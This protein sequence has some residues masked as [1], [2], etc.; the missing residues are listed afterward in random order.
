MKLLRQLGI[1][2]LICMIGEVIQKLT[3]IPIPGN[4]L[5]MIILLFCLIFKVINLEMIE[6]VSKFL[7]DHLAFFFIPPGVGLIKSLNLLQENWFAILSI[8]VVSTIVTMATTGITI[9]I[10][11]RRFKN[12]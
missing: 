8:I 3:H 4:V 12:D 7:L 5:G 6:D 9:Q 1:V 2:L 11:Q 10:L